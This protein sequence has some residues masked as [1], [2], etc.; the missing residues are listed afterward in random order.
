MVSKK[1]FLVLF[2][3][4]ILAGSIFSFLHFLK[5]PNLKTNLCAYPEK[6]TLITMFMEGKE[7]ADI[8]SYCDSNSYGCRRLFYDFFLYNVKNNKSDA[9]NP[10]STLNKIYLDY[11]I[12][13][14]PNM[15]LDDFKK[16]SLNFYS[17]KAIDDPNHQ[18]TGLNAAITKDI[19][20]CN[21]IQNELSKTDCTEEVKWLKAE[22]L[23]ECK[24]IKDYF[25][26]LLCLKDVSQEA[27]SAELKNCAI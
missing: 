24:E 11:L 26:Y 9:F 22:T 3:I 6:V 15:N 1:V 17:E 19:S 18:Y 13:Y 7:P 25:V 23:N 12:K 4:I 20:Y 16:I 8:Q 5:K 14:Q 2:I 10:D 21:L 27:Y